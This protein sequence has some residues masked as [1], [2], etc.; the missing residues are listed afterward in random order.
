MISV[1]INAYAC[2]PDMG[3]EPG[4]GWKWVVYL[5]RH[6][7]VYVITEGEFKDNIEK[8]LELLPQKERIHFF[9]LP[10]SDKI[11]KMCW[12]QGDWRFYRHYRIWQKKALE[13]AY[14]IMQEHTIDI[15]HQLNMIGFREPGYL[16]KIDDR[17]FIWG[18]IGGMN[19]FPESYLVK[20]GLRRTFL[21]KLKNRIN[22]YQIRHHGRVKKALRRAD[23]LISAIPEAREGIKTYHGRDSYLISETGCEVKGDMPDRSRDKKEDAFHILWV[24]RFLYSKQ[25]EL[26]LYSIA[27]VKH[28]PGLKFHIIG[29]GSRREYYKNI[30]RRLHL[31]DVCVWHG[32]IPNQEVHRQMRQSHLFF[33]TSVSEATSTVVLEALENHLPVLCFNTCGFGAVVD[34]SVGEKIELSDPACSVVEFGRK[35]EYLY[36]HREEMEWKSGNCHRKVVALSWEEKANQV[37]AIYKSA[38]V[39]YGKDA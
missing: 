19:M 22:T 1:L 16:W 21:V 30:A 6:C 7:E 3:S 26:A 37:L 24:G 8:A 29:D 18:P 4:V 32:K 36:Y 10:V 38:L 9:Y 13:V 2:G 17:P 23:G 33:F 27:E 25:L 11:R 35:I 14:R 15:V 39:K 12:N 20:A 31:D 5:A 34:G 28:L